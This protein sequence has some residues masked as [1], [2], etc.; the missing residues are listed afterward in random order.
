MREKTSYTHYATWIR[1]VYTKSKS[2]ILFAEFDEAKHWSLSDTYDTGSFPTLLQH[3]TLESKVWTLM[4][5][6]D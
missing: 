3:E 6:N 5:P 1:K 2:R 4:I